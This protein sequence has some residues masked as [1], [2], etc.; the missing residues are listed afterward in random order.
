[1]YIVIVA[2]TTKTGIIIPLIKE[3]DKYDDQGICGDG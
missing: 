3:R 1:L 2:V